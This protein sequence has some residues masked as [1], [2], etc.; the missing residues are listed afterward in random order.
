MQSIPLSNEEVIKTGFTHKLVFP[1]TDF[2]GL[3]SGSAYGIFPKFNATTTFNAG[4]RVRAAAWNVS[5]AFTF[6]AGTLIF[7]IGD[8][9]DSARYVAAATD[10]KTAAYGEGAIA[11]MPYTHAAADFLI[12]TVTAGAGTPAT[13]AAGELHVY[14]AICDGSTTLEK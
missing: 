9:G 4:T 7:R 10:L 12:I 14:L 8:A 1:Y 3:T 2:T 5:T 11:K 13:I 6:A